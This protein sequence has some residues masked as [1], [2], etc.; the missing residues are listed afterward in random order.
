MNGRGSVQLMTRKPS[1]YIKSI[2]PSRQNRKNILAHISF[3]TLS[4]RTTPGQTTTPV[5]RISGSSQCKQSTSSNLKLQEQTR[6]RTKLPPNRTHQAPNV[7]TVC[8]SRK[9]PS[10][11]NSQAEEMSETYEDG[12][13]IATRKRRLAMWNNLQE[14]IPANVQPGRLDVWNAIFEKQQQYIST[15]GRR[16]QTEPPKPM[17]PASAAT[18]LEQTIGCLAKHCPAL[19]RPPPAWKAEISKYKQLAYRMGATRARPATWSDIRMMMDRLQKQ[20]LRDAALW[21]H[22][23]WVTA[24]R[25]TSVS[26]LQPKH[27]HFGLQTWATE[28]TCS[29]TFCEGKTLKATGPY[30]LHVEIPSQI[31]DQLRQLRIKRHKH[32]VLFPPTAQSQVSRCLHSHGFEIRSIRRGAIQ[33]LANAG[34]PPAEILH[35]SRH[36]DHQGLSAYLDHGLHSKWEADV[37]RAGSKILQTA[38]IIPRSNVDSLEFMTCGSG[39]PHTGETHGI[40]KSRQMRKRGPFTSSTQKHTAM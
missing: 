19:G 33:T 2:P 34:V 23:C 28:E 9:V 5:K 3:N 21:L 17:L 24:S 36:K 13:V 39:S 11:S 30:T 22:T 25:G 27:V 16:K 4:K 29:L 35:F 7:P 32:S 31:L 6:I 8:P 26:K 14:L 1:V 38:D 37:Q 12:V 40:T 18:L 15:H 10:S 20:N